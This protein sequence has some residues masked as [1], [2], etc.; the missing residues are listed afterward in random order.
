MWRVVRRLPVAVLSL[1]PVLTATLAAIALLAA[2]CGEEAASPGGAAAP[3][4]DRA[5]RVAAPAVELTAED[6]EIWRTAASSPARIPVL[7]YHGIAAAGEFA[8]QADAFYAIAPDDFAKQIA[9]LDHAGYRAI[10]LEQ[11]NRFHAGEPVRLPAHPILITFDDARADALLRADPVLAGH[12][13]SATM[14]VDVGAVEAANPEYATWDELAAMQRSGRWSLQLH[15]GRGHHA[16]RYGDKRR[17]VGPFYAY[18]DAREGET[19]AQWQE[20]V[21]ADLDWGED[22]LRAHVP[23][24][25]PLAFAPP[26][27]AYGQLDTNDPHIPGLLLADLR[28]RYGLVFVQADPHAATPGEEPVTRFQLDRTITG[29]GLHDWLESA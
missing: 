2:A 6:R 10:T 3:A 15:A 1:R 11:F 20:R 8:N 12:G 7:L 18:R 5:V 22:T 25:E 24:Y 17:E 21:D 26:Y 29:G 27:G 13:W 9:L 4:A 16:I 14:F 28:E 19:L 23:G